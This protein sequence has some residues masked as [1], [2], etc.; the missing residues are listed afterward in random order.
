MK[1]L[2]NYGVV[3][4]DAKEIKETEGG[5]FGID[6][7]ALIVLGLIFLAGAIIHRCND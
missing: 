3:S 6:D 7:V 1:N 4:L 5:L 2:E